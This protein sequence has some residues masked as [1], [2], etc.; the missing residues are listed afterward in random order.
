LGCEPLAKIAQ[1]DDEI[2]GVAQRARNEELRDVHAARR[3]RQPLDALCRDGRAYRSAAVSPIGEQLVERARL[4]DGTGHDVRSDGRTFLDDSDGQLAA[5]GARQLRQPTR[6]RE[7]GGA[8][9]DHD[10]IEL[11]AFACH[12]EPALMSGAL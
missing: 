1:A 2:T 4:E 5:G 11:H 12:S 8:R 7:T 3:A 10:D 6:R 9:T